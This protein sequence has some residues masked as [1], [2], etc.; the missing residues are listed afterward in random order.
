MAF[1]EQIF[2]ESLKMNLNNHSEW[3]SL[4]LIS[5]LIFSKTLRYIFKIHIGNTYLCKL[6]CWETDNVTPTVCMSDM[7]QMKCSKQCAYQKLLTDC[8]HQ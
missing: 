7:I 6:F 8:V 5:V 3:I 4:C 2:K 1:P